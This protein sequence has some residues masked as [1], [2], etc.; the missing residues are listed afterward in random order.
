MHLPLRCYRRD[1]NL[2]LKSTIDSFNEWNWVK[3]NRMAFDFYDSNK[4]GLLDEEDLL[5]MLELSEKVRAVG[6]DYNKLQYYLK[7][8]DNNVRD[9]PLSPSRSG[10]SLGKRLSRLSRISMATITEDESR[11]LCNA[12]QPETA[13]RRSPQLWTMKKEN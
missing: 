10:A 7:R 6:D 1:I 11:L 4:N 13:L 3:I 8:F 12:S 9:P 5:K 2:H